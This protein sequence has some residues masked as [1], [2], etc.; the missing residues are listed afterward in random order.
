MKIQ[1]PSESLRI[2]EQLFPYL[3]KNYDCKIIQSKS[4]IETDRTLVTGAPFDIYLQQAI[5][6]LKLNFFYVDNGYIGNH[7]Y[8]KPW[9]YRISYNQLQNTRIGKFGKSRIHTL[10]LDGR[11]EDWNNDGDYNLLVMPLANKLFTWFNKDYDTWRQETLEHYQSLDTYCVVRDKPG[12][13]ASRQ[14]RFRDILPLIRGARKVITHHSMAA[15]EAL[16]L[17]KPIEILGESAVQHWQNQTNF[18]RQE[19]LEHIAHS[20]FNRDEF[21]DGT[22]WRVTMQYQQTE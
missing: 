15:V 1:I 18:D 6:K 11:Y 2:R 19:M 13:R 20:Q 17:G 16:C 9:Y 7:N 22:A 14:Q 3:I 10:E 8:K 21:A 5:R 12:G 4:D